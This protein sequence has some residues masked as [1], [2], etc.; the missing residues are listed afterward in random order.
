V[1]PVT[2]PCVRYL[3]AHDD[4]PSW[5]GIFFQRGNLLRDGD[6]MRF[7]AF[8]RTGLL[9]EDERAD[10]RWEQNFDEARIDSEYWTPTSNRSA[11]LRRSTAIMTVVTTL[12]GMSGAIN[13]PQ[14]L[15]VKSI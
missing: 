7:T 9:L 14:S 13:S 1:A 8:K 6:T 2:P 5:P 10:R 4:P 3:A 12:E 15:H 11:L